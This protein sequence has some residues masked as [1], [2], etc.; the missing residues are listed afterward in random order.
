MAKRGRPPMTAK[1]LAAVE[2][3]AQGI[4]PY[5]IAKQ[6][7][8][9]PSS[10]YRWT[11][12]KRQLMMLGTIPVICKKRQYVW[13]FFWLA[14]MMRQMCGMPA[15]YHVTTVEQAEAMY[16]AMP[17]EVECRLYDEDAKSIALNGWEQE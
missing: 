3:R 4:G 6:L 13:V 10:V 11:V 14:C 12:Q 5:A 9:T 15:I 7:N 17:R 8:V 2:L 1:Q 16:D